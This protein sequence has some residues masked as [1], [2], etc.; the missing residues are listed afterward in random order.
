MRKPHQHPDHGITKINRGRRVDR[1]AWLEQ[2]S[3]PLPHPL[4]APSVGGQVVQGAANVVLRVAI[5]PPPV[6]E[7]P[8]QRRLQQVLPVSPAPGQQRR[9][10]QQPV[11]SLGDK[12]LQ[13]PPLLLVV[14]L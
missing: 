12:P 10:M 14:H 8:L 5:D 13:G 2:H 1:R 6:P 11:T 7:Q 4:A 9:R 3:V